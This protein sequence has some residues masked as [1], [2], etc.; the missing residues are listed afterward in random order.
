MRFKPTPPAF[1]LK[2][3]TT[4]NNKEKSYISGNVL[5][6][7]SLISACGKRMSPGLLG[8]PFPCTLDA[9]DFS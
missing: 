4:E 3:N 6:Y 5:R 8:I 9:R 2:R 1:E 7:H